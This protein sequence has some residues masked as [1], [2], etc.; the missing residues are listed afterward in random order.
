V[1]HQKED[2]KSRNGLMAL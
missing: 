1:R 2:I